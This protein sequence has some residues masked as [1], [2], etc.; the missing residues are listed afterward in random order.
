MRGGCARRRS[1]AQ[2]MERIAAVHGAACAGQLG[3]TEAAHTKPIKH[4]WA[5]KTERRTSAVDAR[6][7]PHHMASCLPVCAKREGLRRG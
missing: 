2:L 4:L 5:L 7:T 1:F 6:E 3:A